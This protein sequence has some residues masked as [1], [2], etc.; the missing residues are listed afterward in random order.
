MARG[1]VK[2]PTILDHNLALWSIVEDVHTSDQEI[3]L[4]EKILHTCTR[5]HAP[6]SLQNHC[7]S[8]KLETTQMTNSRMGTQIIGYL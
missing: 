7:N 5:K 3:S 2:S 4:L 1:S 6:V 8:I